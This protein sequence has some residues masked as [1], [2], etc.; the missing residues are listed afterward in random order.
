M[1][2]WKYRDYIL[3][4]IRAKLLSETI[5]NH[6]GM[7]WMLFEPLLRL[8]I[9][10]YVFVHLIK[11]RTEDFTSF[12]LIGIIVMSWFT[13][14][15]MTG[16]RSIHTSGNL[17]KQIHLPK[18]LF[19][20]IIF[21]V[22]TVE[23]LIVLTLLMGYFLFTGYWQ[24]S[25]F[26]IPFLF[27]IQCIITYGI[28]LI[29]AGVTPFIPDLSILLPSIL[30][31]LFFLSGVFYEVTPSN[32][33]YDIFML[34]PLAKLLE[35]YRFVILKGGSPEWSSLIIIGLV[36]SAIICL[37]TLF[38]KKMDCYYPRLAK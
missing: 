3:Y 33:N 11:M 20:T 14:S 21:L 2:L 36:G 15:V 23:F 13:K 18:I 35:Q 26:A 5:N 34:N 22:R 19:P 31:A 25:W 7:L 17:M 30:T 9:Y 32:P 1:V 24:D 4:S 27:F 37:M 10:Y 12:L 6:L 16:A 29:V 38:I 8:F 28:V